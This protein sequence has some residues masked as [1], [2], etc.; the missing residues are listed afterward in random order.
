MNKKEPDKKTIEKIILLYNQKNYLEALDLSN[1]T[2]S[3]YPNSILINNISGVIH[4]ELKNYTLAKKLFIKVINL[5]PKYNDGYYNLANIYNKL[6]E[7]DKAIKNYEKVIELDK[8]YYKAY[9][10]LGNIFRKRSLNKKA[11]EY[12]ILTLAINPNYTRGFYNLAGVLQHFILDEKNKY[13]NKFFL[14]LLE[15]KII[16]RPNAIATNVINGLFLNT[17]LKDNFSLMNSKKYPNNFNELVEGL[18]GNKLL[19]QFMKVCPIPNYYFEINFIKIRNEILNR[20]YDLKYKKIYLKFLISLSAQCFLNE[21]IYSETDEEIYKV[22]KISE[23]IKSNIDTKEINDL[24]ILILSCYSPLYSF[25]WCTKIN[26]SKELEETFILQYKNY[27]EEKKYS[28]KITS[29]TDI[30]DNVSI[31]VKNQYEENPYPRWTNLGLSIEPRVI[32][33]VIKDIN[34][35]IDLKKI[36]FSKNV[37]IL[38]AGCGTGQH[39]ITTASKYKNAEIFALDLSFNSLAYAKRKAEEL[40]CKNINFIQGDLLDLRKLNKKFDIIESVGVLHHMADPLVG[41]KSLTD[42][43]KKDALMLIGLYSEK[44]R[45]NIAHVRKIINNLKIRTTK[46]NIINFRKDIFEN[47]NKKWE[48]I[49]YSP[50]FY[51]TSGVR[52]LLFHVQ[53]HRFTIKKIRSNMKK[54]GLVFLGFEDTYVLERFRKTYNETNNL[55]DL[56]KWEDFERNNPRIFSGMYQFW[57]KKI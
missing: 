5:N 4:T 43:L 51:S 48:S 26:P 21:Y 52:D 6:G 55:Y 39:A 35:D 30:N 20:I 1:K 42:C 12:Y 53:E 57:C 50:D 33:D 17:N 13:I 18:S 41:W 2:I 27:N 24:D 46:K 44:A 34:L 19:L 49:K 47:D 3:D 40:N 45:E 25:D 16:V 56:D 28:K 54:L 31:K 22:N 23:R 37:E 10:N 15:K 8:S 32:K 14:F 11:L 29:I 36:N 7:E 38:I 9:N